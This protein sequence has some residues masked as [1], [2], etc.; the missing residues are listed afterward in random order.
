MRRPGHRG[1]GARGDGKV[2]RLKICGLTNRA[3]AEYALELGADALGFVLEPSSPRH[4]GDDADL[5]AWVRSVHPFVTTVAV[6]GE[7]VRED[8]LGPFTALQSLCPA[9]K[10]DR[11]VIRAFRPR[12][13]GAMAE[14]S[15]LCDG[16]DALLLDAYHPQAYGGTGTRVDWELA[17]GIVAGA[18]IP[19]ILAGGLTPEN[20]AE[21]IRRVRP[22]AVDVSSGVEFRAGAKDHGLMRAFVEAVRAA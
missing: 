12:H 9:A 6:F 14:L 17:A 11:K 3:D 13:A 20:V 19:V 10:S 1:E 8:R 15:A 4:V 22:S 5:L 16:A 2:T 18:P 7:S 21:A